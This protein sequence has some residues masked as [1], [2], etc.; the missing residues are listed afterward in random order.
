MKG[1][2]EKSML[3]NPI[4]VTGLLPLLPGTESFATAAYLA[5]GLLSVSLVL[6][7][8]SAALGRFMK[9]WAWKA[10]I[11]FMS[12]VLVSIAV[13][14]VGVSDRRSALAI[15]GLSAFVIFSGILRYQYGGWREDIER[16]VY[17]NFSRLLP[18]LLSVAG[19]LAFGAVRELLG[20]GSLSLPGFGTDGAKIR[21]FPFSLAPSTVFAMPAGALLIAG[22][23]AAALKRASA[24]KG[25][26]EGGR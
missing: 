10:S 23:A 3:G 20:S 25:E 11:V 16:R 9:P 18:V 14:A 4:L 13:Q 15:S 1:E 17:F 22:Y 19:L 12:A 7:S 2:R 21:V 5:L 24:P 8:L 26:R 6:Q